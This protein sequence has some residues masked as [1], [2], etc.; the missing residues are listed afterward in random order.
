MRRSN[1]TGGA[2]A[3]GTWSRRHRTPALSLVD[4][5]TRRFGRRQ[6]IRAPAAAS[7]MRWRNQLRTCRCY[8]GEER[9]R[10]ACC[11]RSNSQVGVFGIEVK[12]SFEG[13]V[14]FREVAFVNHSSRRL[15]RKARGRE[16]AEREGGGRHEA[17]ESARA[18]G[19]GEPSYTSHHPQ[20]VFR[21]AADAQ[22]G[23][24]AP[25]TPGLSFPPRRKRGNTP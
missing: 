6:Q 23:C 24:R 10:A 12:F 13:K 25:A 5:L 22:L 21:S 15:K 8:T 16:R 2:A 19:G 9:E 14:A 17:G 11:C 7:S 3:C 1:P 18:G 4:T 20:R